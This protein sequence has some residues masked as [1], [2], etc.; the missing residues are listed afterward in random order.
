MLV[1]S[2]FSRNANK[3]RPDAT[4][5]PTWSDLAASMYEALYPPNDADRRH[6]V[7]DPIFEPSSILGLAQE[8][9]A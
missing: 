5:M 3:A 6:S 1:G 9:E 7:E 8:Y 4:E 2:G